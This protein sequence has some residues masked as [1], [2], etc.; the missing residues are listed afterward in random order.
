MESPTNIDDKGMIPVH[1]VDS[2]DILLK[3]SAIFKSSSFVN[4]IQNDR[5]GTETPPMIKS[6]FKGLAL[7]TVLVAAPFTSIALADTKSGH[8]AHGK[9]L[10]IPAGPNAPSVTIAIKKDLVGGWNLH[11]MAR[12]FRF[13]PE[14]ASSE[15]RAGEGHAH[16]YV[17]GK[18]IARVYG[19]WFHIGKLPAGKAMVHVTLNAND[20]RD[21]MV[22]GKR[23][24]SSQAV[25][26]RRQKH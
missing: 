20:H 16:L 7:A 3:K 11:I 8:H 23:V 6:I 10:M 14:H 26:V 5:V 19:P 15:H 24:A 17:N 22:G 4:L 1:K 13:A 2:T 9:A 18:K 12:N 21:L 25:T